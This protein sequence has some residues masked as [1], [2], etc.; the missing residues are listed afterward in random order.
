MTR[1]ILVMVLCWS[2]YAFGQTTQ[3]IANLRGEVRNAA[4]GAVANATVYVYWLGPTKGEANLASVYPDW[5]KKAV[6]SA[7]GEFVLEGLAVGMRYSVVVAAAG[8]P[9]MQVETVDPRKKAVAQLKES[10][11]ERKDESRWIRGRVVDVQGNAVWGA[12]VKPVAVRTAKYLSWGQKA[13]AGVDRM[14]VTDR[15]GKFAIFSRDPDQEVALRIAG[16]A[17]AAQVVGFH[18]PG[19]AA[20]DYAMTVGATIRGKLVKDGKPVA[21]ITVGAR[22]SDRAFERRTEDREAVT[23]EQGVFIIEHVSSSDDYLV[24][25]K[26]KSAGALG[27][28]SMQ[29]IKMEGDGQTTDLGAVALESGC[30]VAGRIRAEE[31]AALPM[32]MQV[33][34]EREDAR[35]SVTAAIDGAGY[36]KVI[37]V[38][39][40]EVVGLEV[41]AKGHQLSSQNFSLDPLNGWRLLGLVDQN[42]PDL[43]I[44]LEKARDRGED[45]AGRPQA[46]LLKARL[47]GVNEEKKE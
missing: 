11:E 28:M 8:Y 21:G 25:A 46:D 44:L 3:A 29:A 38:P 41:K 6:S 12:E 20:Q 22:E 35:D 39:L 16:A 36:F 42:L 9:P 45:I 19:E 40:N 31:G 27:A 34:L 1:A 30:V 2:G 32:G 5:G 10:G 33:I 14:T 37:G 13:M 24:Y 26:M 47:R 43:E 23:D 7:S 18:K 15:E 17:F 4:G